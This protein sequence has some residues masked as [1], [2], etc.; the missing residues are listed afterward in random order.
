[1]SS[2]SFACFSLD[3]IAGRDPAIHHFE[4]ANSLMDARESPR[5][6]LSA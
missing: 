1:M 3:V 4:A 6:T 2:T 5:M